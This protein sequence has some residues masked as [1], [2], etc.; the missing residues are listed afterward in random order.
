MPPTGLHLPWPATPFRILIL[1]TQKFGGKKNG[2][3]STGQ[4]N[5]NKVLSSYYPVVISYFHDQ[6]AAE[7]SKPFIGKHIMPCIV[8]DSQNP[9]PLYLT[10]HSVKNNF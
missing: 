5:T 4:I 8:L 9:P 2:Q 7:N 10:V 6:Q 1:T 3:V